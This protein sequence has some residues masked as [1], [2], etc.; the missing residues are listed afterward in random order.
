MNKSEYRRALNRIGKIMSIV[1]EVK[2]HSKIG[3]ELHRLTIQVINHE[4]ECYPIPLPTKLELI[5]FWKEQDPKAL[6]LVKKRQ[7]EFIDILF[8]GIARMRGVPNIKT[9]D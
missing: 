9:R 4:K 5:R 2:R 7:E 3:R 1:P 8:E 6:R